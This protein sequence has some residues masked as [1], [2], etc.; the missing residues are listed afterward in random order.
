[1]EKTAEQAKILSTLLGRHRPP[2]SAPVFIK[3]C[4]TPGLCMPS[5]VRLPRGDSHHPAFVDF[6]MMLRKKVT[7]RGL[8]TYMCTQQNFPQA[9]TLIR[10]YEGTCSHLPTHW[11]KH[12]WKR[13]HP[14]K[15]KCTHLS[16][17]RNV[18]IFAHMHTQTKIHVP[19]H[20]PMQK[21]SDKTKPCLI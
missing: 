2:S 12:T 20:P 10:M 4:C 6:T 1:M 19:A 21:V 5:T 16:G 3:A 18:R 17:H 11:H 15:Y 8:Y 13:N 9:T 7:P 14:H